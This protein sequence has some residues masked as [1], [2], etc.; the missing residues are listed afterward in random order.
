MPAPPL[1]TL[2]N[3]LRAQIPVV[4]SISR[5]EAERILYRN[6]GALT[7]HQV[8]AV[9]RLLAARGEIVTGHGGTI[10]SRTGGER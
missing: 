1:A 3:R 2:A 6:Y 4:G 8:E 5:R 7:D 10:L 9:L